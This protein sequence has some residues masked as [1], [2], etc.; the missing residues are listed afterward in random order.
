MGVAYEPLPLTDSSHG[1]W[2]EFDIHRSKSSIRL[3]VHSLN[4][5]VMSH[6]FV[7]KSVIIKFR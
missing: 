5:T 4:L 3:A 7:Y 2:V 1:F 6:Q